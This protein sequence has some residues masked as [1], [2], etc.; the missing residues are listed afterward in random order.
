MMFTLTVREML[1]FTIYHQLHHV[2][3]VKRRLGD[4][5]ATP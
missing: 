1:F 2:E 5:L 3:V 4:S